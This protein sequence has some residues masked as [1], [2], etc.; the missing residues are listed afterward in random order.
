MSSLCALYKEKCLGP[1]YVNE[2]SE[3]DDEEWRKQPEISGAAERK[4]R[5]R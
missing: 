5:R 3:V 4:D 2:G 1:M